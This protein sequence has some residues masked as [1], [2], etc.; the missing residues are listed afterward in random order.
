[1]RRRTRTAAPPAAKRQ[2]G[3]GERL[4]PPGWEMNGAATPP[5]PRPVREAEA[6]VRHHV[7]GLL[8]LIGEEAAD[9]AGR[10]QQGEEHGGS[11][12]RV[13][14]PRAAACTHRSAQPR[15]P[16]R[17]SA[18]RRKGKLRPAADGGRG[19]G[20]AGRGARARFEASRKATAAARA[21]ETKRRAVGSDIRSGPCTHIT[22]ERWKRRAPAIATRSASPRSG[23]QAA[24][25]AA[26]GGVERPVA[27]QRGE[28]AEQDEAGEGV[29]EGEVDHLAEPHE[30]RVARWMQQL[31]PGPKQTADGAREEDLVHLPEAARQ[32]R[33]AAVTAA[34]PAKAAGEARRCGDEGVH[35]VDTGH[36]VKGMESGVSSLGKIQALALLRRTYRG[37]PAATRAHVLGRFLLVPVLGC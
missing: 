4:R 25:D 10:R 12:A 3:E 34:K 33:R 6:C 23:A 35:T 29:V 28:Q 21:S 5:S 26:E 27:D 32:G 31:L 8:P 11:D 14:A 9:A 19:G 13:K 30:E 2:H 16:P 7:D 24:G 1:M 17:A 22:G 37:A 15:G 20:A 36:G 18:A